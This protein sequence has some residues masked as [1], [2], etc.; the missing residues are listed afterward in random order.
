V[1]TKLFT[2]K[3]VK[4]NMSVCSGRSFNYNYMCF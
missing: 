1:T 3:L 4:N 2:I